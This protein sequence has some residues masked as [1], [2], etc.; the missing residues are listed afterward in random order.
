MAS[1]KFWK[2]LRERESIWLSNLQM[3]NALLML[4][5]RYKNTNNGK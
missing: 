2:A 3:K 5:K 4:P 1:G